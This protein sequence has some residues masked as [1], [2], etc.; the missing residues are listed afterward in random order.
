ML[1]TFSYEKNLEASIYQ[2]VPSV[3]VLIQTTD[4]EVWGGNYISPSV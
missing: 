1:G 4:G 2:S 3:T